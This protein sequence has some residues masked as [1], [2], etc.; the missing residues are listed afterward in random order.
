M[1]IDV[2][3]GV[4]TS[5]LKLTEVLYSPDVGYTLMAAGQLDDAGFTVTYANGKWIMQEQNEQQASIVVKS[6]Q[7]LY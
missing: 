1:V 3:N 7:G 4:R 2:P 6:G 5:Q